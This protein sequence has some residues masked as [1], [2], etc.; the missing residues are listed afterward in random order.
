MNCLRD[1]LMMLD[2]FIDDMQDCTLGT[3]GS[4]IIS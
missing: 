1:G 4:G 3:S 2:K